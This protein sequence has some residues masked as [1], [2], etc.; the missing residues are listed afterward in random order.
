MWRCLHQKNRLDGIVFALTKIK[1]VSLLQICM[2]C[3]TD[4]YW[5]ECLNIYQVVCFWVTCH[6]IKIKNQCYTVAKWNDDMFFILFSLVYSSSHLNMANC[7]PPSLKKAAKCLR[8]GHL[9]LK[10]R[11]FLKKP[12]KGLHFT[13]KNQNIIL[14]RTIHVHSRSYILI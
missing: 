11:I 8:L 5:K 12:D 2:Q 3:R 4:N 13:N 6:L 14:F 7:Y 9:I 1:V 10:E